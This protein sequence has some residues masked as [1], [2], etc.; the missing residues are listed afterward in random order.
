MKK[1]LQ[2]NQKIIEALLDLK[3]E[4]YNDIQHMSN[5]NLIIYAKICKCLYGTELCKNNIDY[6]KG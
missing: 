4:L 6:G 3:Y 5:D 1:Q 2:D